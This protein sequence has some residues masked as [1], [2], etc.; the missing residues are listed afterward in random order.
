MTNPYADKK[1]RGA[2]TFRVERLSP[3]RMLGIYKHDDL[4]DGV[5]EDGTEYEANG[6]AASS[7]ARDVTWGC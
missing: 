7:A 6:L 3:H 2:G 1:V 5:R 4:I